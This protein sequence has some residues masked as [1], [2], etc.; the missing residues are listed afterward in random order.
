MIGVHWHRGVGGRLT[1]S[2]ASG[3]VLGAYLASLVGPELEAKRKKIKK[4]KKCELLIHS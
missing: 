3:M 4:K 1:R 2:S